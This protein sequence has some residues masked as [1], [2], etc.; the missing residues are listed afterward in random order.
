MR[1][2]P[3]D[4]PVITDG[5]TSLGMTEF[6]N[7]LVDNSGHFTVNYDAIEKAGRILEQLPSL[8]FDESLWETLCM[9]AKNP[10]CPYP[11]VPAHKSKP[12]V[13]GL[14]RAEI[15]TTEKV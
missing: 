14:L 6:I 10:T 5:K 12:F 13:D 3:T 15:V 8:R 1:Q 7:Y 9:A 2:V 4:V 11:T